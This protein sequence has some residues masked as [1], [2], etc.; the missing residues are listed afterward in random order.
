MKIIAVDKYARLK[1]TFSVERR[2][3]EGKYLRFR[4]KYATKPASYF[5][6]LAK[7]NMD[8]F[9]RLNK[10]GA[11]TLKLVKPVVKLANNV[12]LALA[13]DN[14]MAATKIKDDFLTRIQKIIFS[15]VDSLRP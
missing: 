1:N 2:K 14:T 13:K 12:E 7:N 3:V 11:T 9:E 6:E 4:K 8:E 15:N 10:Q 5:L